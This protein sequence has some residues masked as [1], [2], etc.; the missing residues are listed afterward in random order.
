MELVQTRA[1]TVNA[2][3]LRDIKEDNL[4]LKRLF[5]EVAQMTFHRQAAINHWND[6]GRTVDELLDQMAMHFSLEEAYGYFDNAIE[7]AVQ[8]SQKAES[9]RNQH[10]SLFSQLVSLDAQMHDLAPERSTSIDHWLEDF[11]SFVQEFKRHEEEEVK[12]ILAAIDDDLGV[13]D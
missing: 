4:Q 12:M 3:F 5:D 10:A 8:W 1:T 11:Q 9:L 13:G 7:V 2:A 6:L